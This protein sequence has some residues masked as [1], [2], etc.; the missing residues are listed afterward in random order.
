VL[1]GEPLSGGAVQ[2]RLACPGPAA[3]WTAVGALG[4]PAITEFEVPAWPVPFV[5]EA[6]TWN[7]YVV[8]FVNPVT[9]AILAGAVTVTGL[10]A[11]GLGV[12]V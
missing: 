2:V 9:V 6:V 4:A 3:A 5:L 1:I 12:I 8:P 10:P 7:V 11:S